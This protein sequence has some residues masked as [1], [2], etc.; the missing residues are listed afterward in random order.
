[1]IAIIYDY[2]YWCTVQSAQY[3]RIT[4]STGTLYARAKRNN[5]VLYNS[6]IHLNTR[7][8]VKQ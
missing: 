5:F 2:D 7:S 3:G 6:F 1:M 4:S 8:I